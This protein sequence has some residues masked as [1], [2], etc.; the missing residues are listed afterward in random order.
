MVRVISKLIEFF[1]CFV[2][3][4]KLKCCMR[5]LISSNLFSNGVFGIHGLSHL[6]VVTTLYFP[7]ILFEG[8]ETHCL[9]KRSCLGKQSVTATLNAMV[10]ISFRQ[11][12]YAEAECGHI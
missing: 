9:V 6:T 8:R 3:T 1:F 4:L 12:F 2:Y 10:I 11:I 5:K 7:S